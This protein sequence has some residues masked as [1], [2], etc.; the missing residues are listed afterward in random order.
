MGWSSSRWTH[1]HK[2]EQD[3]RLLSTSSSAG[4]PLPSLAPSSLDAV[5]CPIGCWELL[6]KARAGLYLL[7]WEIFILDTNQ[8]YLWDLP[9]T[10]ALFLKQS[11]KH[12]VPE[13]FS[14][15]LPTHRTRRR[16]SRDGGH[17][18][19]QTDIKSLAFS[20]WK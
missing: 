3:L 18:T 2:V 10:S 12:F 7:S 4:A 15:S 19:S 6:G 1:P 14:A 16:G 5:P 11:W 17:P 13:L 8:I 9:N 20:S